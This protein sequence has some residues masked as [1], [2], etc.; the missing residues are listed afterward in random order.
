MR[1]LGHIALIACLAFA[2]CGAETGPS[3]KAG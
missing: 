1:A 3:K 2:A